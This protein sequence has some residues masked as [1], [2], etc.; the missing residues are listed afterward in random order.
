MELRSLISSRRWLQRRRQQQRN[1]PTIND[2][3]DAAAATTTIWIDQQQQQQQQQQQ[4]QQWSNWGVQSVDADCSNSTI[5]WS[6]ST[7]IDWSGSTCTDQSAPINRSAPNDR[8]ALIKL[9]PLFRKSNHTH[10]NTTL[11]SI[12][13]LL[14]LLYCY[15]LLFC[16]SIL[17]PVGIESV[18]VCL[19]VFVLN[20][21]TRFWICVH[22]T[23]LQYTNIRVRGE[24]FL[25]E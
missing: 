13:I 16:L 11:L 2:N 4:H 24:Y 18:V 12:V 21:E 8:S 3:P 14:L 20:K 22:C 5:N 19:F 7:R 25:R 9:L 15:L 17:K 10:Y 6:G 1:N 23:E